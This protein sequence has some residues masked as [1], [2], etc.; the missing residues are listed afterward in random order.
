M[1][2]GTENGKNQMKTTLRRMKLVFTHGKE[3]DT[4]VEELREKSDERERKAKQHRLQLCIKHQPSSPCS[5]YAEYNCS[6]CK[7]LEQVSK[8]RDH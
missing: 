2:G 8:N 1:A 7:L 4:I 6:S 3:L 5:H